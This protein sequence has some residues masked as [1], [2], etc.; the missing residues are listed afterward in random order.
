MTFDGDT[1]LA[2]EFN[3]FFA[4]FEV[5]GAE[6]EAT[7]S[8]ASNSHILTVQEDDIQTTILSWTPQN[9]KSSY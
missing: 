5:K 8:P 4:R 6:T 3:C 1:S 7:S 9:Q 2:E